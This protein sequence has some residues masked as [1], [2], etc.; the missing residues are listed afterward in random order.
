[1]EKKGH[2]ELVNNSLI[3]IAGKMSKKCQLFRLLAELKPYANN[4][5]NITQT[6]HKRDTIL[7]N[8]SRDK[9]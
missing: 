7:G 2:T 6:S 1:M 8:G 5:K 4:H 3:L 9:I